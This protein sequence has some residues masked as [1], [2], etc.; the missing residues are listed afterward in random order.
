MNLGKVIKLGCIEHVWQY[1][2]DGEKVW[3]EDEG[4][5]EEREVGRQWNGGDWCGPTTKAKSDN[6]QLAIERAGKTNGS[7]HNWSVIFGSALDIWC[8]AK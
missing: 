3:A 1:R 8:N 7:G 5:V 4:S 2:R 6:E